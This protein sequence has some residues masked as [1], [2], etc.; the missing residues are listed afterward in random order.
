MKMKIKT[1]YVSA[2][3]DYLT[4]G[5]E[6]GFDGF[7]I[8]DDGEKIRPCLIRCPHLNGHAWTI[9]QDEPQFTQE[10]AREMYYYLDHL[11]KHDCINDSSLHKEVERLLNKLESNDE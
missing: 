11:T 1:D 5:K 6:Y 2:G 8:T 10:Q 4:A 7:T 9:V 3:C